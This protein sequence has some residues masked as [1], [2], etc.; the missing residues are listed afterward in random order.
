MTKAPQKHFSPST[1]KIIACETAAE[2]L[3]TMIP[4]INFMGNNVHIIIIY[5]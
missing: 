1:A 3:K 4:D 2:E 5:H